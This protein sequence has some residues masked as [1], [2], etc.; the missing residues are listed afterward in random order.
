MCH[1]Y[2]RRLPPEHEACFPPSDDNTLAW[3][4]STSSLD[5]SLQPEMIN[6][7]HYGLVS[8]CRMCLFGGDFW[9]IIWW[10]RFSGM[11][12]SHWYG[13]MTYFFWTR[14]INH[15][16]IPHECS[17]TTC[18]R[19]TCNLQRKNALYIF[20]WKWGLSGN[21]T[22]M[23]SILFSDIATFYASPHIWLIH[24]TGDLHQNFFKLMRQVWR[25][26]LRLK[27]LHCTFKTSDE[28]SDKKGRK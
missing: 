7:Y 10:C 2:R 23:I 12:L 3:K 1:R 21:C 25:V 14:F 22:D 8:F 20:C 13:A 5:P 28:Y 15:L 9:F 24:L 18:Y 6:I 27:M 11:L 19:L 26:S 16:K 4:H 17:L